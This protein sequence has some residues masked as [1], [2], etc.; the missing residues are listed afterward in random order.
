MKITKILSLALIMI[1]SASV[2]ADSNKASFLGTWET[3]DT[4][5][6]NIIINSVEGSRK[7]VLTITEDMLSIQHLYFDNTACEGMDVESEREKTIS[8][9]YIL[10][11]TNETNHEMSVFISAI[12]DVNTFSITDN[13][14]TSSLMFASRAFTKVN[15]KMSLFTT[16]LVQHLGISL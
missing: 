6:G 5:N 2:K 7:T 4:Q 16:R 9:H 14:L 12:D 8:L 11:S 13:V 10:L 1:A 3:C 15:D